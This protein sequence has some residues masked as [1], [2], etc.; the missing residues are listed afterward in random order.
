M[1]VKNL[2][3]V[4]GHVTLAGSAQRAAR[5]AATGDATVVARLRAAGAIVIGATNMDELA[6]GFTTENSHYGATRNPHDASRIAG[7]SSGG[8]AAAVAAGAVR[9]ALGTDTNGSVRVPA[10]FC[11]VF[12]LRPTFG[13]LPRTGSVLFAPSLDTVGP[14]ARTVRDLAAVMD[15]LAGPDGVDRSCTQPPAESML[16]AMDR[17]LAGLRIARAAGELWDGA[18]PE[19]AEA[20][21]RVAEALGVGA[22]VEVPEVQRARAAAI[23]I[24]AAEGAD[25]HQ[26]LLRSAPA[27]FDPRVRDRFLA[28][29]TVPAT[30]YLAA[31][32]FRAWW[33]GEVARA[34]ESVDVL[35]LPATACPA[36]MIDQPTIEVGG[37]ALPSGAVLGRFTQPLGLLGLPAMTVPVAAGGPLPVAAQLVGRPAG[38]AALFRAAAF[39]ESSG[40]AEVRTP[41]LAGR[42]R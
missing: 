39:L 36:P 1:A 7:G 10:A 25:Q 23:T 32:R 38:E 30:D 6:Y 13:A 22:Q 16:A 29:L 4:A 3:D 27:G 37:V 2:F 5:T 24:T 17:G 42:G 14:L 33:R 41:D 19:V 9:V 26:R 31:Q 15:V 34:L 12:G 8:S 20:V 18:T 28:G 11:G 21:E 35:V 40:V